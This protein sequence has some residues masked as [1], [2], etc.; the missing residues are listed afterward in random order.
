MRS[1]HSSAQGAPSLDE[2]QRWVFV[3][4]GEQKFADE[5]AVSSFHELYLVSL[6][7]CELIFPAF[8]VFF[9]LPFALVYLS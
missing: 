1:S 3:Y 7:P 4:Y 6:S 5:A 9:C 8:C 2:M